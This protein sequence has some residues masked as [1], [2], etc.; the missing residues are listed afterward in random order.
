MGTALA[1]FQEVKKARRPIVLWSSD[2]FWH[3][4]NPPVFAVL[5]CLIAFIPE[6]FHFQCYCTNE[7]S[8]RLHLTKLNFQSKDIGEHVNLFG[9]TNYVTPQ[10]AN[11]CKWLYLVHTSGGEWVC[12][13]WISVSFLNG[14]S[15][16]YF[17]PT[18]QRKP[19]LGLWHWIHNWRKSNWRKSNWRLTS[20]APCLPASL[21]SPSGTNIWKKTW[22]VEIVMLSR[23]QK[24]P[25]ETK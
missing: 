18:T 16:C 15:T 19:G 6:Y 10:F 17:R 5:A 9:E 24:P 3:I 14:W 7:K 2:D 25:S 23:F 8:I 1:S 12:I 21:V 4:G 11:N 13:S 20:F 22:V